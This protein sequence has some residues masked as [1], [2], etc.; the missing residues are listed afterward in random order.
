MLLEPLLYWVHKHR[1]AAGNL[2]G[3]GR[4]CPA[5][6]NR[7]MLQLSEPGKGFIALKIFGPL[8]FCLTSRVIGNGGCGPE[9]FKALP[10]VPILTPLRHAQSC[11]TLYQRKGLALPGAPSQSGG[12][13]PD[14][15]GLPTTSSSCRGL[16]QARAQRKGLCPTCRAH[17][18]SRRLPT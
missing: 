8:F 7:P 18:A 17:L 10:I 2:G 11:A 9:V 15:P 13:L 16:R 4:S 3:Q 12:F 1:R 5:H 6:W 14:K